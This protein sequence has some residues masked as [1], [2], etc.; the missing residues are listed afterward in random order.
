MTNFLTI[1]T[2]T[3]NKKRMLKLSFFVFIALC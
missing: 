2:M 3:D 1:F